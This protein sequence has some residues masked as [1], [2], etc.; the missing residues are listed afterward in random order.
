MPLFYKG[1]SNLCMEP[2]LCAAYGFFFFY[3]PL[4]LIE[5]IDTPVF[6]FEHFRFC[7]YFSSCAYTVLTK[8][9]PA[10]SSLFFAIQKCRT[11]R[12]VY[13]IHLFYFISVPQNFSHVTIGIC[14]SLIN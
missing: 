5:Y 1:S 8:K 3:L 9:L 2:N 4:T 6:L 11:Q 12:T 7:L 13:L 14:P 10:I